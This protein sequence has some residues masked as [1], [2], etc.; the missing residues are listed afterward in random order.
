MHCAQCPRALLVDAAQP[1]PVVEAFLLR[2]QPCGTALRQ[3][4]LIHAEDEAHGR[5]SYGIGKAAIGRILL[6]ALRIGAE[7]LAKVRKPRLVHRHAGDGAL[8]VIHFSIGINA[9]TQPQ[10]FSRCRR[11]LQLLV[12]RG[13]DPVVGHLLDG[14]TLFDLT[15]QRQEFMIVRH[16]GKSLLHGIERPLTVAE[17]RA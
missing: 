11:L 1:A 16:E 15:L 13:I 9:V 12:K 7:E 4:C 14:H 2:A 3:P 6:V 10:L 8:F 17:V 5:I